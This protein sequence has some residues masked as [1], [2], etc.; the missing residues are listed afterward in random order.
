MKK[1]L[2]W[3][4]VLLLIPAGLWAESLHDLPTLWKTQDGK[5]F[6]FADLKGEKAIIGMV[7]TNCAHACPMTISKMQEIQKKLKPGLKYK[8]ILASFDVKRDTPAQ[9]KKT[10]ATRSLDPKEWLLLSPGSDEKARELALI[11]DI[12]Y[13]DVGGGEFAHSNTLN[14]IDEK[15]EIVGR[16]ATLSGDPSDLIA[17][18]NK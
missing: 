9:L 10:M 12:N 18:L 11:L 13:K 15:G 3:L 16:L 8:L 6:K 7:Y 4:S 5:A 2:L 1:K 14:F 17:T